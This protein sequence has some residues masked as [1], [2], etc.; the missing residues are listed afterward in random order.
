MC[1]HT[2][3][4][5]PQPSG[6]RRV[7]AAVDCAQG[8][9]QWSRCGTS[10]TPT[11]SPPFVECVRLECQQWR[12][13]TAADCFK[14]DW[15]KTGSLCFCAIKSLLYHG[16]FRAHARARACKHA[17]LHRLMTTRDTNST[18]TPTSG[19]AHDQPPTWPPQ[20]ADAP[21]PTPTPATRI[22]IPTHSRSTTAHHPPTTSG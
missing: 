21:S 8:R 10:A 4:H 9:A 6:N 7:D 20:K 16:C 5:I 18:P 1:V 19:N 2:P 3:I 12:A 22:V 13:Q 11:D 17:H 15:F 14:L